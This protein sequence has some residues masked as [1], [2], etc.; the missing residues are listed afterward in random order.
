M[1]DR[2]VAIIRRLVLEGRHLYKV[3]SSGSSFPVRGAGLLDYRGS[4][5]ILQK[6]ACLPLLS[7]LLCKIIDKLDLVSRSGP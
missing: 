4:T 1:N 5:T 3:V 2:S 7:P 6:L